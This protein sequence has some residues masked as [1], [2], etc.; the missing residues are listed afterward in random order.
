MHCS[1]PEGFAVLLL[2]PLY[3]PAYALLPLDDWCDDW[4]WF[5]PQDEGADPPVGYEEEDAEAVEGRAG[6]G[7]ALLGGGC[8]C[9]ADDAVHICIHNNVRWL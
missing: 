4:F 8:G 3:D 6:G 5:H 9:D 7:R 2:V 1:S